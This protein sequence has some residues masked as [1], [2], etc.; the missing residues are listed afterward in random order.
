MEGLRILYR[1]KRERDTKGMG[2][3]EKEGKL[4]NWRK[5]GLTTRQKGYRRRE[6]ESEGRLV[7]EGRELDR[8]SI[9][10]DI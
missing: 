5:K 4:E 10:G 9:E 1:A 3:R 7:R 6:I 8:R 2:E